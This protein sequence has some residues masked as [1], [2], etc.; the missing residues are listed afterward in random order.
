MKFTVAVAP[1]TPVI[2]N[3]AATIEKAYGLM[4]RWPLPLLLL[5]LLVPV[6]LGAVVLDLPALASMGAASPVALIVG[7]LSASL[8]GYLA[9]RLVWKVMERGRLAMFAPYCALVGLVVILWGGTA[10][11]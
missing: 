2:L 7:F 4:A 3:R 10:T 5:P 11:P 8:S 9:I 1:A 6:I